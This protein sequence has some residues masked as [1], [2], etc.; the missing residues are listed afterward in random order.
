PTGG[1]NTLSSLAFALEHAVRR[2]KQRVIYAIPYTSII[3]QTAEVFRDVFS[4]LGDV[5]IEHHSQAD[6]DPQQETSKSRLACEN[7]DAPLIV[8][9]NV[10]F[11][12]SLYAARTSTTV[13]DHMV[14]WFYTLSFAG[15]RNH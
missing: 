12:E 8:T 5:A 11:F 10:Q 7:W 14:S 13:V 15:G 6:V 2:G 9:T 3:E 4:P 1:G